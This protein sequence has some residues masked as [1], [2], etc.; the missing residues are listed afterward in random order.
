MALF[1][2]VFLRKERHKNKNSLIKNHLENKRV[3]NQKLKM[4][5]YLSFTKGKNKWICQKIIEKLK[6]TAKLCLKDS[7]K[8]LLKS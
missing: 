8:N 2:K 6:I 4:T 1:F 5:L 7:I 3:N